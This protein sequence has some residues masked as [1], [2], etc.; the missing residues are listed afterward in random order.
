[1]P[2]FALSFIVPFIIFVFI[3]FLTIP[4]FMPSSVSSIIASPT[5]C[6]MAVFLTWVF[7]AFFI[8]ASLG[9]MAANAGKAVEKVNAA[10][11]AELTSII[12][13]ILKGGMEPSKDR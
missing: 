3:F 8:M 13:F 7:T 5:F 9:V 6:L 2:F 12:F 11:S 4:F 10:A 1:M